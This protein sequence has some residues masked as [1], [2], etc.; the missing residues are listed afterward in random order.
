MKLKCRCGGPTKVL[1]TRKPMNGDIVNRIRRCL[2][3]DRTF[4][5][6]ETIRPLEYIKAAAAAAE[7]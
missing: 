6:V 7:V 1:E 5:T 2:S 3:C 4:H